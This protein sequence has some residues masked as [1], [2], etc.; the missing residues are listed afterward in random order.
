MNIKELK[1]LLSRFDTYY[2]A[3]NVK[4]NFLLAFNTFFGGAII[5]SRDNILSLATK[6]CSLFLNVSLAIF[7]LLTLIS[8]GFIILAINPFLSHGS[9]H[10]DGYAS[11][12]FFGSVSK[13]T[14][15]EFES[16]VKEADQEI[17]NRD[18]T[19]QIHLLS[20][21]LSTKYNRLK[22]ASI[23]ISGELFVALI[24]LFTIIF[25]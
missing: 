12:L 17:I 6:D 18:F 8:T 24:I 10:G 2:T 11:L 22:I 15:N 25:F 23:I 3:V 1:Y 21:G 13:L 16:R 7:F 20:K 9:K 14:F 5:L 19:K 4:S